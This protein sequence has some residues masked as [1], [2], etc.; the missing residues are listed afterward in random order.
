MEL[1]KTNNDKKQG[2]RRSG[3][4]D[5]MVYGKIPPQSLEYEKAVLGCCMIIAHAY[6]RASEIVTEEM[7]YSDAH[8]LIYAAITDMSRNN[9]PVDI[10]TVTEEL[11]KREEL[12][13]VGGPYYVTQLTNSV[14]SSAHIETYCRGILEKFL[15]R[16]VIRISGELIGQAYEDSTDAFEL[17]EEA[18]KMIGGIS[19]NLKFG[20]MVGIDQ[21]LV[22]AVREIEKNRSNN[23]SVTGV[24]SG[25]TILDHA[26]RGWQNSDFIVLAAR[27]S[28]G[29]TAFALNLIRNAAE[30]FENLQ[31]ANPKNRKYVAVWSLEMKRV[32]LVLRML[33]AESK[34]LL[35]RIQTG[36]L[37]D[38]QMKQVYTK[39]VQ[40]L[41]RK[42]I[43]F[44][45]GTGLTIP[46]LRS[47]ARKLKRAGELGMIVIDY[48][49]L[50]HASNPKA[51]REQQVSEISRDL[52]NLAAELD[53][54]VIALS[55]LSRGIESR[56]GEDRTPQL[57]DLRE[58]GAIEQ[59]AD[60]VM[61]L[62]G[63]DKADIDQ[64]A[65]LKNTR[66]IRIA[67]QRDGFLLKM[68]LD[69]KDEI[70]F[71]SQI[72]YNNDVPFTGN[73]RPVSNVE[74]EKEEPEDDGPF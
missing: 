47:K 58:S 71:F 53:V 28:V 4:I 44:D 12:D 20:D 48:L 29:K 64:N 27:P 26:T 11:K 34:E 16:E 10:I 43:K 57:S 7:F 21:V 8:K 68:D 36:K 50:I 55:Q 9:R 46:K 51:I 25:Y 67:K 6:D 33:A 39:G 66:Y 60:L 2:N 5:T 15:Q 3:K 30:H 49:Q 13:M 70:Q 63:P 18:E 61:F 69:F 41:A 32:K 62:W 74:K 65:D 40:V 23:S 31:R 73:W 14:V 42:N 17:L 19:S 22:E 45:D 24:P 54:P 37:S 1:S 59:D 35:Y 72:E 56:K 52:K 38:D